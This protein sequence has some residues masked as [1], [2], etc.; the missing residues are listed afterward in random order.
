ML[1][2]I[3]SMYAERKAMTSAINQRNMRESS[4]LFSFKQSARGKGASPLS[5]V[6]WLQARREKDKIVIGFPGLPCNH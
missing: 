2:S 4:S 6:L 1:F 5:G 3:S